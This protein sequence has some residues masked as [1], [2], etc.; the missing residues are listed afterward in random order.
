MTKNAV[1]FDVHLKINE[2]R[3]DAFKSIAQAMIA[4]TKKES[5]ALAYEW[6]FNGDQSHCRL[7]EI[8]ADQSAVEAHMAGVAVG[9]WVPKILQVSSLTGFDVYGNPGAESAKRLAGLGAQIFERWD[10]LAAS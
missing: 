3:L 9:E 8:Y 1:Y 10:G 6:Y 2:G 4:A 5:G 7:Q